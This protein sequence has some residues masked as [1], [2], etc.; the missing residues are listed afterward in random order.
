MEKKR[1]NGTVDSRGPQPKGTVRP[2]GMQVMGP[3]LYAQIRLALMELGL[4]PA[5]R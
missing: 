5:A 4:A 2:A 3:T 1:I